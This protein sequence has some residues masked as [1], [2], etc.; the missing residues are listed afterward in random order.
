MKQESNLTEEEKFD[1]VM[2]RQ[3]YQILIGELKVSLDY[4]REFSLLVNQLLVTYPNHPYTQKIYDQ[5][6]T[7][8][9]CNT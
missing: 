8:S 4:F 6:Y 9:L 1:G 2:I 7:Q 5:I 3:Y